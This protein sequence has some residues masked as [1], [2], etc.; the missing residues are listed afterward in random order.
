M[1]TNA[2]KIGVAETKGE[3]GKRGSRKETR[4]EKRKEE[5]KKEKMI[6]VRKIVEEWEI[7]DEEE[8]VAKSEVE[9]K[10]FHK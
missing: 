6:E 5:A 9:A 1:E 7:W 3:R 2:G 8:E 10:K 4:K